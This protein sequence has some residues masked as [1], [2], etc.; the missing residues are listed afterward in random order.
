MRSIVRREIARKY[1]LR[2]FMFPSQSDYKPFSP[3]LPLF[4][5]L[6]D[7]F[8]ASQQESVAHNSQQQ[9]DGRGYESGREGVGFRDNVAGDDRRRNRG[10]L[11][12]KVYRSCKRTYTFPRRYQRGNG[13]RYRRGGR[14]SSQSKADPDERPDRS[15]GAR[16]AEDRK[17]ESHPRYHHGL[18][19]PVSIVATLKQIVHQPS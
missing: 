12:T 9:D 10:D 18:A 2:S 5:R 6:R 4:F 14:Q 19:N 17:T 16:R 11:A 3:R 1:L 13:P 7:R 15:A 8:D